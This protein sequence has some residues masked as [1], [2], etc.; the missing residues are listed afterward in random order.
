MS[1][2]LNNHLLEAI[3]AGLLEK[4]IFLQERRRQTGGLDPHTGIQSLLSI[5]VGNWAIIP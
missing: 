2:V 1:F 3:T 4:F 5:V